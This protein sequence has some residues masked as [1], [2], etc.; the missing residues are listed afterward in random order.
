MPQV[1]A[2]P[3]I[4][5]TGVI[6]G[7]VL[8]LGG[9]GL[10]PAI[11]KGVLFAQGSM[12][13]PA[14]IPILPAAPASQQSWLFYNFG[15][16]WYWASSFTPG[17]A[18]DA[19]VGWVVTSASEVL[20]VSGQQ[21]GETGEGSTVLPGGSV[22]PEGPGVGVPAAPGN[23]TLTSI[24]VIERFVRD[25]A[26]FQRLGLKG[27]APD[28]LATFRGIH[29]YAE[30]PDGCD[31][32]Q[33]RVED[34]V[35]GTSV[36]GIEREPIDFGKHTYIAENVHLAVWEIPDVEASTPARF[37]AVPYS[38]TRENDLVY[39]DEADPTP[40]LAIT[41]TPNPVII[42]GEEYAPNASGF[43][44]IV[45]YP[46]YELRNNVWTYQFGFDW[47]APTSSP[48]FSAL[49]GYEVVFEYA[50]GSR[51]PAGWIAPDQTTWVSGQWP[52]PLTETIIAWLVSAGAEGE[53]TIIEGVTPKLTITITRPLDVT[54]GQEYAPLVTG[55]TASV[56]VEQTTDGVETYSFTFAWG[57]PASDE[58]A[59]VH[60]WAR[61]TV[62][63]EWVFLG[64]VEAID[65]GEQINGP[66]PLVQACTFDIWFYSEARDG[67]VNTHSDTVTPH[68]HLA[69]ITPSAD[70]TIIRGRVIPIAAPPGPASNSSTIQTAT[71]GGVPSFR[72]HLVTSTGGG[73][74]DGYLAQA[75]YYSDSG[76]T[77][78]TS[79]WIPLGW[80]DPAVTTLDTPYW[81]RPAVQDYAKVRIAAQT[82]DNTLGPWL[83]SAILT[84]PASTGLEGGS[85]APATLVTAA[86]AN[87]IRPVT[88]VAT[89][90]ALPALP[91]PLYPPGAAAYIIDAATLMKV[92]QANTEWEKFIHGGKDVIAG[93]ITANEIYAHSITAGQIAAGAIGTSELYAG[94]ILVGS[95][96]GKPTRF[97]VNDSGGNQVCF[98]GDNGAGFIGGYFINLLVGPTIGSPCITANSSGVSF[99][100]TPL[101][102]V[103]GNL[104]VTINGTDGIKVTHTSYNRYVLLNAAQVYV[105]HTTDEDNFA[106]LTNTTLNIQFAAGGNAVVAHHGNG[107][108]PYL[109]VYGA[110]GYIEAALFKATISG[111]T[112]SGLT[113]SAS[114]GSSYGLTLYK[115]R[116]GATDLEYSPDNGANWY[117]VGS[118][119]VN[120]GV[121]MSTLQVMTLT[122]KA[123]LVTNVGVV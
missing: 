88:L 19:F 102:I 97:R 49:I 107:G 103:N 24:E 61:E 50:D 34:A 106:T 6:A 101:T 64:R 38:E 4:E 67:R 29:V 37:Y 84:R 105:G 52:C 56:A 70:P 109:V 86:F 104:T 65:N 59:A 90:S 28:P 94:E 3:N 2:A 51:A 81:P 25:G 72:F 89:G 21:I 33:A 48:Q 47:I 98:I 74:T 23:V 76:A 83:E 71:I 110:S 73:T 14:L 116:L 41:L 123:G 92:N 113:S 45:G 40:S 5:R 99:S 36:V 60:V 75:R 32:E 31:A 10:I 114:F 100:N 27:T 77:T 53:N 22:S 82:A 68:V 18:G 119:G 30:I 121:G 44:L 1:A 39:A 108:A 62:R 7:F 58:L 42:S 11:T 12:Y 80:I 20:A 35:V 17:T 57:A 85:I 79:D 55:Q 111:S 87:T 54:P 96:G 15:S 26:Q 120:F 9:A 118:S 8:S 63:D 69:Q 78:P 112:Y 46:F 16:A 122:F 43:A 93:T 13:R 117:P 95:G 115:M 91:N 66:H